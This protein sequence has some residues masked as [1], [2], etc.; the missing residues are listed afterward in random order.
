MIFV[1]LDRFDSRPARPDWH[2]PVDG[3]GYPVEFGGGSGEAGRVTT[4]TMISITAGLATGLGSAW[5]SV[6]AAK[7]IQAAKYER[8]DRNAIDEILAELVLAATQF[9]LVC[10]LFQVRWTEVAP[11]FDKRVG[12]ARAL[13][14][15]ATV[16]GPERERL[17]KAAFQ[18]SR[19]QEPDRQELGRCAEDLVEGSV[20]LIDGLGQRG[21]VYEA[22]SR[23]YQEV[24]KAPRQAITVRDSRP[25]PRW[26]HRSARMLRGR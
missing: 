14:D 24:L 12:G 11:I 13:R 2:H 25:Q 21:H 22:A 7:R 26:W 15:M 20:E 5:I 4:D 1:E 23:K 17:F 16:L 18:V 6:S 19:W 3:I 10:H 8:E 9:A